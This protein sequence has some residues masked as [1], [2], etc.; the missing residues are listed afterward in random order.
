M[1]S[2]KQALRQHL[3]SVTLDQVLVSME[4]CGPRNGVESALMTFDLPY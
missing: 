4:K 1:E 3:S 2:A